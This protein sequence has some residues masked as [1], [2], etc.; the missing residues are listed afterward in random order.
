VLATHEHADHSKYLHEYATAGIPIITSNGTAEKLGLSVSENYHS[1][2]WYQFGGFNITPFSVEHDCIEPFGFLIRHDEIGTM[3]FATDTKYIRYDF[4]KL[5]L[6]HLF[7][8]CNYDKKIIDKRVLSGELNESLRNR[9]I[10]S[11]MSLETC[12]G[13]IEHNKSSALVNVCLLHLSDG[14]SNEKMFLNEVKSIVDC[15]VN[16]TIA[17]SGDVINMDLCPW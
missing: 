6:N 17:N 15:S 2:Y 9:I 12:I 13:F 10:N 16:V 5:R 3:L 1:G 11:H 8:E 4:S 7:I 14:N